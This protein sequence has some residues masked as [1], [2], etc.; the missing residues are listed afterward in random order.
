MGGTVCNHLANSAGS[1]EI[2]TVIRWG[3]RDETYGQF[4]FVDREKAGIG[5][6][7]GFKGVSRSG[8][9]KNQTNISLHT[10]F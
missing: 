10:F 7:H 3:S 2:K 6:Q 5:S 9:H 8:G 4:F 1:C